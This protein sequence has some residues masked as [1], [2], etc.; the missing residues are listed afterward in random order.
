ML[1][2]NTKLRKA[3]KIKQ[4]SRYISL[5]DLK[6]YTPY[7]VESFQILHGNPIIKL[8]RQ[9]INYTVFLP[10]EYNNLKIDTFKRLYLEYF[11]D[12]IINSNLKFIIYEKT[13][14]LKKYEHNLI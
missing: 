3:I 10:G 8:Q 11:G 13:H 9:G 12:N 2:R 1:N 4:P 7:S 14:N 6:K 5:H